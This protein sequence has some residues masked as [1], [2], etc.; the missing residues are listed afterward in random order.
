[1]YCSR[2][3]AQSR[4]GLVLLAR[5]KRSGVRKGWFLVQLLEEAD[6]FAARGQVVAI[7]VQESSG[8]L[9]FRRRP[10]PCAF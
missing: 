3:L 5:M 2:D 10:P 4:V 7:T 1:M 8:V 9:V 6:G